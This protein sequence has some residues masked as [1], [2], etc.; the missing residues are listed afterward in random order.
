MTWLPVLRWRGDRNV[1]PFRDEMDRFFNS[2]LEDSPYSGFIRRETGTWYPSVDI[3]ENDNEYLLRAEIPGME[4]KDVDISLN[5]NVLTIKGQKK[6]EKE[7]K[8]SNYRHVECRYGTFQRTFQLPA[9]VDPHNV[10]A[11]CSN[12]VLTVHIAKSPEAKPKKIEIKSA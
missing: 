8:E 4:S 11:E 5:D 1:L 10:K 7:E 3:E 12:G 9:N 6:V 2:F